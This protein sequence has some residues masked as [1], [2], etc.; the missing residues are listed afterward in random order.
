MRG[1][2][3]LGLGGWPGYWGSHLIAYQDDL[4]LLA[5]AGVSLGFALL[6]FVGRSAAY[7]Q[8]RRDHLRL[9]T[10]FL[11]LHISYRRLLSTHPSG[12]SELFPPEK[13]SWAQRRLLAPFYGQTAVVLE[14]S[15]YPLPLVFLRL[16]LAPQMFAPHTTGLVL[17]VPDWL[18]FSTELDSF[19]GAWQQL[20]KRHTSGRAR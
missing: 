3:L 5:G 2:R 8:P 16:F 6:A 12:F 19:V 11:R 14:L 7:V 20:Q 1:A 4:W 10:P 15:H 9:V 17:L 13:A 18:T